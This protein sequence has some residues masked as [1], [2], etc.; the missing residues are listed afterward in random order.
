MYHLVIIDGLGYIGLGA[1][2]PPL[3]QFRAER[4]GRGSLVITTNLEFSRWTA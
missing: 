3:F 2:G 1:G 4:Y